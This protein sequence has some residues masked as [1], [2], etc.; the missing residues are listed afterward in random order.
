MCRRNGIKRWPHRQV[1]S[2]SRAID[3]IMS[4]MSTATPKEKLELEHMVLDLQKKRQTVIDFPNKQLNGASVLPVKSSHSTSDDTP[5]AS[6]QPRVRSK[7]TPLDSVPTMVPIK[8]EPFLKPDHDD[9][10]PSTKRGGRWL[11]E[12]HQLFLEGLRTYGKNWKKVAQVVPTRSTVQIRTHAQKFFKRMSQ[13]RAQ[14]PSP[15]HLKQDHIFIAPD[16]E[17]SAWF[18][19][20][21]IYQVMNLLTLLHEREQHRRHIRSYS[22]RDFSTDWPVLRSVEPLDPQR[23]IQGHGALVRRL[24]CDAVLQTHDGCVNRLCWNQQGTILASGSDDTRVV[25]W[26]YQRRKPRHVITTGHS[27]NI[28]GVAFVPGTNDHIVASAGMDC[29][30]RLHYAPFRLD[31]SKFLASHRGRV[32][33]L[34]TSPMVPHVFWSAGED[35]VVRQFDVRALDDPRN[36]INA[37]NV[38]I[39]LGKASSTSTRRLRAMG[40]SMHPLDSTKM[41]IACGDHYIRLFDRRML[42]LGRVPTSNTADAATTTIPVQLFSPP[43]MHLNSDIEAIT[44]Y[45]YKEAHGTSVQFNNDGSQLLTNYHNDH[46]YLFD[47]AAGNATPLEAPWQHGMYMDEGVLSYVDDVNEELFDHA[48]KCME[49]MKY[50]MALSALHS[51]RPDSWSNDEIVLRLWTMLASVYV[52]RSWCGDSFLALQYCL[53]CFERLGNNKPSAHLRLIY[54]KALSLSGRQRACRAEALAL[55]RDAPELIPELRTYSL[56]RQRPSLDISELYSESSDEEDD[57]YESMDDDEPSIEF[58]AVEEASDSSSSYSSSNSQAPSE[59]AYEHAELTW[60]TVDHGYIDSDLVNMHVLRRYIG[61]CNLHTDIKEAKFF[62]EEDGHIVAGS[63]DGY[64]Y[65]W[66]KSTGQLVNALHADEDIVNCV[67]CHPTEPVL[68]TSGIESVVRLWSPLAE[69]DVS[70]MEDHLEK[71]VCDNQ[72]QMTN[73]GEMHAARRN[74][75]HITHLRDPELLRMLLQSR[76]MDEGITPIPP[77]TQS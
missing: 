58:N 21:L 45:H 9:D 38:L 69:V 63:D 67:Q 27:M 70:P 49:T 52:E 51:I 32:K 47:I 39:D 36:D 62:G 25:L 10:S 77:C 37:R 44:R 7:P 55:M 11:A 71:L 28:F 50:S 31:G 15:T 53:R 73:D 35:G 46:I 64:A 17:G 42:R 13:E 24:V 33:D 6:P 54:V 65:I 43:H 26:D 16:A 5:R 30:V 23:L 18:A 61:Y 2:L 1:R 48:E 3:S 72:R 40:M 8:A 19:P 60:T 57:Y 12:E 14:P 20:L 74:A 68:A 76:G 34:A 41:A 59:N 75:Y 29:E 56:K 66:E 22:L 4:A